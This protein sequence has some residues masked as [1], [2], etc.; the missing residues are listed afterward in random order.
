MSNQNPRITTSLARTFDDGLATQGTQSPDG[1]S[2]RYLAHNRS[3]PPFASDLT[4]NPDR[5]TIDNLRNSTTPQARAYDSDS[6]DRVRFQSQTEANFQ[7]GQI[8]SQ[9]EMPHVSF[10][11]SFISFQ[12]GLV[13]NRCCEIA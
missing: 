12:T 6:S 5:G 13:S 10:L 4:Q 9:S 11:L 3:Q 2:T 8:R 1:H 7:I